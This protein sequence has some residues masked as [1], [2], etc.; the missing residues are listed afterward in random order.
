M[1]NPNLVHMDKKEQ[2][3]NEAKSTM[4][5]SYSPYSHL[6]VGA[7]IR[8]EDGTIFTG[9]N[10]ENASYSLTVCAE[11]VA[12]FNAI[13]G[14]RSFTDLAIRPLQDC[15]LHPVVH[16]DRYCMSLILK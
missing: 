7:A 4:E 1:K 14:H 3:M 12:I 5:H 15:Q 13:K 8:A 10:I 11:R 6:R 2:L 16:A 9:A